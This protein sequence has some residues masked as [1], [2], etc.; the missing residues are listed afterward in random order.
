[1][2]SQC[3]NVIQ[4]S[5]KGIGNINKLS[6]QRK[7]LL[8]CNP[9]S[10]Y[11]DKNWLDALCQRLE[12]EGY[13]WQRYDTTA[14]G[15]ATRFLV[16]DQWQADL[17]IVAGGDGTI[18]EVAAG[19]LGAQ[20]LTVPI[21]ALSTGTANVLARELGLNG[22]ASTKHL[23]KIMALI[24]QRP[25]RKVHLPLIN[26]KAMLLMAGAGFDAWVVHTVDS[27][28]KK[29][30]GKLA[31]VLAMLKETPKSSRRRYLLTNDGQRETTNAIIVSNGT[32]YAGPYKICANERLES[33]SLTVT[34]ISGNTAQFILA[35]CALPF[36]LMHKC[37]GVKQVSAKDIRIEA[38]DQQAEPVQ[39]DGD[40]FG[41]LPCHIRAS[42]HHLL[43]IHQQ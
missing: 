4:F 42:E 32:L 38:A 30:F 39:V 14:G 11:S 36:G 22:L 5:G 31:Y 29:R 16:E 20:K 33:P 3:V 19:L 24:A 2:F 9:I 40:D 34:T 8:I 10:G 26:D 28:I 41:Q 37:P 35:L 43:F 13:D 25:L 7:L 21:L 1:M 18:N 15:D 23:N 12:Q 27:D 6:S 17:I